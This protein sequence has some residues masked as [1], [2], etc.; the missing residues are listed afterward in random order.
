MRR[1]END[2]R[3]NSLKKGTLCKSAPVVGAGRGVHQVFV[4]R[5][6]RFSRRDPNGAGLAHAQRTGPPGMT[7][8]RNDD[9]KRR[10]V[11]FVPV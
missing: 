5:L 3:P 6:R 10:F 9:K 4:R 2:I 7:L 8:K 1:A 11:V